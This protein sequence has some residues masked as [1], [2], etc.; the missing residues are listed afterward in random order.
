MT[1]PGDKAP[2]VRLLDVV[3]IGP[4]MVLGGVQ[5]ARMTPRSSP[6]LGWFLITAGVCTIVYNHRNLQANLRAVEADG[7]QKLTS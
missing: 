2:L 7:P 3:I 1:P 4:A 6:A 5:L